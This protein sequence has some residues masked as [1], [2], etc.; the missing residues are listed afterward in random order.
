VLRTE[1][2]EVKM[3]LA[4]TWAR[5]SIDEVG[6]AIRWLDSFYRDSSQGFAAAGG[7]CSDGKLNDQAIARFAVGV[8][9]P[10]RAAKQSEPDS[11][12]AMK[13]AIRQTPAYRAVHPD[14]ALPVNGQ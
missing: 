1:R 4:S 10:A 12:E 6:D 8:Y 13:T 2:D 11:I 9:L 7:L 14:L 3:G 5:Q